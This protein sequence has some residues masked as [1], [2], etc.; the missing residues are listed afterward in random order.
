[1]ASPIRV[2][3]YKDHRGKH[4]WRAV[5]GNNRVVGASSQG[6]ALRWYAKR[7]ASRLYPGCVFL[8]G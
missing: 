5:A 7:K 2:F 6:Y 4:R 8:D 3:L 1:M